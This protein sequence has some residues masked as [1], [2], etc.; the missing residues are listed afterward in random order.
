MRE[1]K[2][3]SKWVSNWTGPSLWVL[4]LLDSFNKGT[5]RIEAIRY[6]FQQLQKPPKIKVKRTINCI[7]IV[8]QH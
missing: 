7:S 3:P 4:F 1:I 8:T 2:G 5:I 6:S